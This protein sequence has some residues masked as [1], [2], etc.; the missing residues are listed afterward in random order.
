MNPLYNE[1]RNITMEKF[2]QSTSPLENEVEFRFKNIDILTFNILKDAFTNEF[3]WGMKE[4]YDE[5]FSGVSRIP[6]DDLP[7]E[8]RYI[9]GQS[10]IFHTKK[11][12]Q[13][14]YDTQDYRISEAKED[15]VDGMNESSFKFIYN[16]TH[17]R[18]RKRF[19]FQNDNY[20]M[21]LTEVDTNG[22]ISYEAELEV[23]N[24]SSDLYEIVKKIV[25]LVKTNMNV[26]K[27]YMDM[28]RTNRFA[29][30]LPFTLIRE[31]F[32]DG[33]LS[34]GY[35]VTDKAD[36]ERFHLFF[37]QF[38]NMFLFDRNRDMKFCGSDTGVK[39]TIIDGE[40]V[41]GVFYGFDA[42]FFQK[43]DIRD[44]LLIDRLKILGK[45][46][47][48]VKP[49]DGNMTLQTKAF[50]Y[51]LNNTFYRMK[52]GIQ[53][54]HKLP[55]N[56][57]IGSIS[58]ELWNRKEKLFKYE[59]DGLIFTPLL[60]GYNNNSIYKW[61]PIDTI[62]FFVKKRSN[63]EWQL[64]IAGNIKNEYSN[65]PF[66]GIGG[67]KFIVKRGKITEIIQNKIFHDD[68]VSEKLRNG[69]INVGK[70]HEYMDKSIIEFFYD[71]EK[72]TFV[73][74][75]VRDDKR[76]ANNMATINDVWNSLKSPITI[77][78]IANSPYKMAVR[79][80]HNEIKTKL[81]E[82]HM[83][84][85]TV[86]DIGFGAGGDI[87]K[88]SKVKVKCVT[89][90][91]I[92]EPEYK[93][94]YFIKFVKVQG[95]EYNLRDILERNKLNTQYDIINIQFA[96]HYFFRNSEVLN[97]FIE[98]MKKCLK[99]GGKIVMTV[100]DGD[101]VKQ[102]VEDKLC[103]GTHE[104]QKIYDIKLTDYKLS[105]KLYGTS[106]FNNFTSEEYLVPVENFIGKMKD[107]GFTLVEKRD[108]GSFKEQLSQFIG[109]M[110]E[111][112]RRYSFLNSLMVFQK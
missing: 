39:N 35:S 66:N 97:N 84:N 74:M 57:N 37:N 7:I 92:V 22:K 87:H 26:N 56:G 2:I 89:G 11:R 99:I 49:K 54:E 15:L 94:P 64:H 13:R 68:T 31:K 71:T 111:A 47:K 38:G 40:L 52:N 63:D 61:K 51:K 96:A 69:Y 104:G 79:P 25:Y 109:V 45:I 93:L 72:Q 107:N 41:N 108:F 53:K 36:G 48:Y 103:N 75:K 50:Y 9:K 73:P 88:Y 32:D 21:D 33:V 42:L 110:C 4:Q 3:K 76:F 65:L 19:S 28:V 83:H 112:E 10:D 12:I 106:Y 24:I 59:L 80:F 6:T 1:Q 78:D 16:I 100:L 91:D 14:P 30:P 29:G 98:N 17:H 90:V 55:M 62:D 46:V 18:K 81:I 77:D 95:D 20:F 67:G 43:K 70:E 27:E 8:I 5:T 82:K 60:K 85:K 44:K 23:V 101:K 58:K 102:M 105:V 86:L 34:C